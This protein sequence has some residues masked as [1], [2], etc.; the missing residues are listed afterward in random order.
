MIGTEPNYSN[1]L[2]KDDLVMREWARK[3]TIKD[4]EILKACK[5]VVE[6]FDKMADLNPKVTNWDESLE[7]K[8]NVW[9]ITHGRFLNL[10]ES[11][12]PKHAKENI[13]KDFC[14]AK[15]LAKQDENW[16]RGL[17]RSFEQKKK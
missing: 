3:H 4:L 11:C 7:R 16:E 2:M 14:L 17:R 12:R 8:Y 9:K 5:V 15:G 10:K 1:H 6:T 13:L